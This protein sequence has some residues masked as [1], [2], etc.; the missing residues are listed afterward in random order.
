MQ[1]I[2]VLD[3]RPTGSTQ[4]FKIKARLRI[5]TQARFFRI[6]T[7]HWPLGSTNQWSEIENLEKSQLKDL[8]IHDEALCVDENLGAQV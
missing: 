1:T 5:N 2:M 8:I 6:L 7:S 4:L 3:N